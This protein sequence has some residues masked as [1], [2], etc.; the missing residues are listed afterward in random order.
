MKPVR[1]TLTG[2]SI[3]L[4]LMAAAFYLTSCQSQS[5]KP[6]QSDLELMPLSNRDIIALSAQDVVEIM[7]RAG[8]SDEQIVRLGTD[9]R[10]DLA[11]Y[12]AVQV[13]TPDSAKIEATFAVRDHCIYISTRLRGS[14]IYSIKSGWL[15]TPPQ[16]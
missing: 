16:S 2:I 5:K 6:V 4:I 1:Q 10:N 3:G 13:K 8:F 9:M 7:R 15:N 12:G 11:L 14:F